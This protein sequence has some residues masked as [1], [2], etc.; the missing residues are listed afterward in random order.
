MKEIYLDYLFAKGIFVAAQEKPDHA[1]EAVLSLAQ[2]FNI[3][4]TSGA[5]MADVG[6]VRV[7]SRNLGQDVPL[8]FYRGFPGSVRRMSKDQLLFDQLVHYAVTYGF[9]YFDEPGHSLFEGDVQRRLFKENVEIK[10]FRII[11]E[12]AAMA[13]VRELVDALL[14]STRPLNDVQ[15]ALVRAYVFDFK[16]RPEKCAC[17]DTAVRLLLDTR[18]IA[19]ARLLVLSDVIRLVEQLQFGKYKSKDIKK[20]NLKNRDRRFITKVINHIFRHGRC[21]MMNCC[22][23]K[24][25]WCGLLHHIHYQPVNFKAEAFVSEIRGRDNHSALSAFENRMAAGEIR[26][27]VDVLNRT[28]GPSMILR[29]LNYL[30]SRC[31]TDEETE[32]VLNSIHS[33]NKILLIQLLLRYA[34]YT[35]GKEQRTFR[36]TKFNQLKLHFET[37]EDSELRKS[38]FDPALVDPI[39][40]RL[41][42]CLVEACKGRLG[43]VWADEDLKEI[44]LPL[45]ENTS[46]G[47]VG[48]LPKGTRL[49]IPEGKK[50]RA[51]TYWE[52]VNDIDLSCFALAEDG[53]SYEFSWRTIWDNQTNELTFSGDQTSGY[54]GGS[55]YFDIDLDAFAEGYPGYR[56]VVFCNNVYTGS[57]FAACLCKA[58]YMLRDSMDSGEVFE[59]STVQSSFII[60]CPGTFAY[61]FAIDVAKRQFV[62]LNVAR[63]SNVIVAGEE[64]MNFLKAYLNVTDII[65]LHDFAMMLAAGPADSPETAD[66]V[67]SDR[68]LTL[69]EGAVQIRSSDTEKILSLMNT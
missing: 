68:E 44:A 62:W 12:K 19:H 17:K 65:N 38:L 35:G 47:G 56:Y 64:N 7:A 8:P 50:V 33:S 45:Q 55:E 41:R 28:K 37:E 5:E 22:E 6:M 51:F 54:R 48:T 57:P 24:K 20:L 30:L 4:I 32:Y 34:G 67:F 43:S 18:D 53:D 46:M 3:R 58:G 52:R 16:Y 42:A 29:N 26:S 49:P 31:K 39:C 1:M 23:K 63:D 59:P 11:T 10:T 21:D 13:M 60:D 40:K 27:A 61:L 66:V 9:G 25:L 36:F 2:L 15:Y 14:D 69:R